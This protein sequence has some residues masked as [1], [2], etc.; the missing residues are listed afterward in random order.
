VRRTFLAQPTSFVGCSSE[1][2]KGIECN[3]DSDYAWNWQQYDYEVVPDQPEPPFECYVNI[4]PPGNCSIGHSAP[5]EAK[6]RASTH[7]LRVAVH[8]REV[9]E[10]DIAREKKLRAALE[11]IEHVARTHKGGASLLDCVW[12]Q[13][14]E[15][16]Q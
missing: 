5:E 15:A 7:A 4:N 1:Y 12:R 13:A 16:L 2:R 14:Q 10:E 9:R 11:Y 8:M 3:L 6:A